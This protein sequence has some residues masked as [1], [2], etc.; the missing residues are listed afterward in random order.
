MRVFSQL[1]RGCQRALGIALVSSRESAKWTS[2][3]RSPE[4]DLDAATQ[5]AGG[6]RV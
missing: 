6:N 5:E 2:F 3:W 1:L 4:R